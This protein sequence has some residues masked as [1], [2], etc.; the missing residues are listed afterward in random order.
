MK[1]V[2]QWGVSRFWVGRL[3]FGSGILLPFFLRLFP[4]G[5]IRRKQQSTILI[6]YELTRIK[7]ARRKEPKPKPA[8]ISNFFLALLLLLSSRKVISFEVK[9][10]MFQFVQEY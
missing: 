5:G 1:T 4:T 10:Y 6:C 3:N 2:K 9:S 7:G 8:C